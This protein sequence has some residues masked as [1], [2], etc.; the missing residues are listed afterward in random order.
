MPRSSIGNGMELH[1]LC[2]TKRSIRAWSLDSVRLRPMRETSVHQNLAAIS[3]P[4][5]QKFPWA[6]GAP[7]HPRQV[8]PQHQPRRQRS[9]H[10][11][12]NQAGPAKWSS[13]PPW[14]PNGL[15]NGCFDIRNV[16]LAKKEELEGKNI[17][18]PVDL[19]SPESWNL[20]GFGL[21]ISNAR[22][23]R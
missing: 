10:S 9:F 19:F 21:E 16:Y 6:L 3:V 2:L 15:G 17:L 12:W 7:P 11:L 20:I 5:S 4:C 8:P 23:L 14:V 18:Y 22:G 1:L 13:E